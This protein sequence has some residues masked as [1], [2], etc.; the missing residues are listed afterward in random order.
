V[1]WAVWQGQGWV[2]WKWTPPD[3]TAA[4]V[5]VLSCV[6]VG[7]CTCGYV[8]VNYQDAGTRMSCN[9]YVL[10]QPCSLYCRRSIMHLSRH[11][12]QEYRIRKDRKDKDQN[13]NAVRA[14]ADADERGVTP[15]NRFPSHS[16]GRSIRRLEQSESGR[17]AGVSIPVTIRPPGLRKGAPPDQVSRGPSPAVLLLARVRRFQKTRF[18]AALVRD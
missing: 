4:S 10:I 6:A 17:G 8:I 16:L 3:T 2:R 7:A 14:V 12:S 18:E 11:V 9:L 1:R 15:D 13:S 5:T